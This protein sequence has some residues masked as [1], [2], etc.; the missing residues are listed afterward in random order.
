[1]PLRLDSHA[2]LIFAAN[3]DLEDYV[4]LQPETSTESRLKFARKATEAVA[5]V[6]SKGVIHGDIA[7]RRFLL[8]EQ[9]NPKLSGFT[10]AS[11]VGGGD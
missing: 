6:H 3:G 8:D 10:Y 11:F 2:D 5:Y 9:L 7:A 1:M 4:K